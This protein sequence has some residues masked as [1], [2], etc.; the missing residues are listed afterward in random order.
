[1]ATQREQGAFDIGPAILGVQLLL[2]LLL[3]QKF[4]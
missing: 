3:A 1:M 2:D 4:G